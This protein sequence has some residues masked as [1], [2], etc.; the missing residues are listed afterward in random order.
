MLDKGLED[1]PAHISS[2]SMIAD[3]TPGVFRY[4]PVFVG[5]MYDSTCLRIYMSPSLFHASAE[6]AV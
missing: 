6:P 2:I 5:K 4:V 3:E 1:D